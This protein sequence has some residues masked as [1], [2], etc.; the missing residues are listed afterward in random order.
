MSIIIQ[1]F[2]INI[3]TVQRSNEK[4]TKYYNKM[5]FFYAKKRREIKSPF[6]K[7]CYLSNPSAAG[8]LTT[9][10]ALFTQ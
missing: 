10:F 7:G 1:K 9:L 4:V 3:V 8:H 5:D 2:Y 6:K